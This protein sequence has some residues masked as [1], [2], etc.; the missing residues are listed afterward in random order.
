MARLVDTQQFKNGKDVERFLDGF[1]AERGWRVEVLTPH[2]ERK[3]HLGDRRLH[4]GAESVLIEY[5]SGIQTFY[6]GNVFLETISVDSTG[7]PGWVYTCRADW[8]VYAALLNSKLLWFKPDNLREKI[9]GLKLRFRTVKTSKGQNSGYD[10]HGVIVPLAVA[11][12]ELAHT[13]TRL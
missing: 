6:T 10:T 12:S 11:V 13:V 8:I 4:R 1:L 2:E 5:K 3:L 9:E 7:A